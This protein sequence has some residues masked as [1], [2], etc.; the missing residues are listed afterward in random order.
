MGQLQTEVRSASP[1]PHT[2]E[3]TQEIESSITTLFVSG[4]SHSSF[5]LPV[6]SCHC[7][8]KN[9]WSPLEKV[10][11]PGHFRK[12]KPRARLWH[13]TGTQP[14]V[15]A[16]LGTSLNAVEEPWHQHTKAAVD[17]ISQ[18]LHCLAEGYSSAGVSSSPHL[19]LR[20]CPAD[21]K[22]DL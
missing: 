5:V 11:R 19:C 8:M 3:N 10:L 22:L 13:G 4:S 16:Q 9:V 7:C 2:G 17:Q 18:P 12:M 21:I 6:V 1:Q 20:Q 14:L 15:I